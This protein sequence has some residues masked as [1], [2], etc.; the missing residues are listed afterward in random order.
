[1]DVFTHKLADVN[2]VK[3]YIAIFKYLINLSIFIMNKS[4]MIEKI[5][6]RCA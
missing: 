4:C 2:G 1:M 3:H 6:K 5:N